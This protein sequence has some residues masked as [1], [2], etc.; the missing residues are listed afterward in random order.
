MMKRVGL[1]QEDNYDDDGDD[2]ADRDVRTNS[3]DA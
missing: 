1:H 2:N 3:A